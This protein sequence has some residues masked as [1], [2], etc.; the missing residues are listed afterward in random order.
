MYP[1]LE[2]LGHEPKSNSRREYFFGYATAL[3]PL[4]F[5]VLRFTFHV[6][7]LDHLLQL[8]V[9]DLARTEPRQV[10]HDFYDTRCGQ[11]AQAAPQHRLADLLDGK[12]GLVGDGD[13]FFAATF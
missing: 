9:I 2:C 13:E 3:I 5:Y 8:P 6:S 12:P 11:I 1:Q 4:T 7:A 10:G